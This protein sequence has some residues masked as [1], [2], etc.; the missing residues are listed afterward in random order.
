MPMAMAASVLVL[1]SIHSL[2]VNISTATFHWFDL[3]LTLAMLVQA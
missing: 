2:P 1:R 3:T